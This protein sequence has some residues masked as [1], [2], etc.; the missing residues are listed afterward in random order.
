MNKWIVCVLVTCISFGLAGCSG[1]KLPTDLSFFQ[2]DDVPAKEPLTEGIEP[3]IEGQASE[4]MLLEKEYF[5]EVVEAD[6]KAVIQNPDNLLVLVNKEY[7]LPPSYEPA[8][9]TAPNVPFSFGDADVPQRYLRKEAAEALEELFAA[10]EGEGVELFAVSGFRSYQ[11]Q[12]GIFTAETKHKG[13][14]HA[15]QAVALPGQS[16]HQTG[17]AM[18]VTS[19]SADLDITEYFGETP[20]G[21]WVQENA[22]LFGFIIRYPEDKQDITQYQYEPW[23]LR[24]VGVET[25]QLLH[26]HQL[27]LEEYFQQVKEI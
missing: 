17:L 21:I 27:T 25:A 19:K 11:R 23:H 1:L 7:A 5:N 16:E 20:E 18:D 8:D 14:E 22:H 15:L 26:Q 4:N 10:A 2:K 3:K 6:S 9:L 13:E 12:E 24:Y